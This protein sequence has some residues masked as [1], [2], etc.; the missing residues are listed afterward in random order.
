MMNRARRGEP[1]FEDRADYRQ[2]IDLPQETTE[3]FN[4]R[5]AAFCLMPGHYHLLLNTLDANLAQCM[6]HINGAYTQ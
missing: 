6:R 1:L 4:V 3:L 5:V 2:F